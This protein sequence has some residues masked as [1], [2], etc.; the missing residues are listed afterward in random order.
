MIQGKQTIILNNIKLQKVQMTTIEFVNSNKSYIFYINNA[1]V[2]KTKSVYVFFY[3]SLYEL[4]PII[5]VY[6]ILC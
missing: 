1:L 4:T 5:D 6:N 3:A 2:Y